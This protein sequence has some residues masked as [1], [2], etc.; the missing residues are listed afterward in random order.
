[1]PNQ[2]THYQVPSTSS[3]PNSRPRGN[4]ENEVCNLAIELM[5]EVGEI[6]ME[7]LLVDMKEIA[8]RIITF[9]TEMK[10]GLINPTHPS[11]SILFVQ[12]K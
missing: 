10:Y 9:A 2:E 1:M 6:L 3:T 5:I 7:H 11:L 4:L 8:G 12:H